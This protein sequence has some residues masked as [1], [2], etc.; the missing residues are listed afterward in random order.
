M[1]RQ[2]GASEWSVLFVVLVARKRMESVYIG[3]IR[4]QAKVILAG[5]GVS[6]VMSSSQSAMYHHRI[7]YIDYNQRSDY[8]EIT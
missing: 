1:E 2:S 5:K 8:E 6:Q 7:I 4:D 3:C